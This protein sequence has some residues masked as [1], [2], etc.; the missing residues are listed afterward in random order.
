MITVTRKIFPDESQYVAKW[1]QWMHQ[2]T[3]NCI[4]NEGL[5]NSHFL[6]SENNN[7]CW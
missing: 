3:H 2:K 7:E 4:Y 6:L 5:C 1:G